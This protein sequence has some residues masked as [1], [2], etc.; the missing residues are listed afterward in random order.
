MQVLRCTRKSL[1]PNWVNHEALRIT[2]L[3]SASKPV[4]IIL[5]GSAAENK[6]TDQSDFDFL[7]VHSTQDAIKKAQKD[8]H[9]HYPLSEY[10]VDIIW[11]T[12]AEFEAKREIGGVSFIAAREGKILFESIGADHDQIKKI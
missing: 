10:P 11:L 2:A 4:R 12:V 5:F 8:L 7:V 9:P 3:L 6:M 1:D